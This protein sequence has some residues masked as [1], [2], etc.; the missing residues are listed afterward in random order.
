[1]NY[2]IDYS[3]NQQFYI[4]WN[5][6]YCMT[7]KIITEISSEVLKYPAHHDSEYYL[8]DKTKLLKYKSMFGDGDGQIQNYRIPLP[9]EKGLHIK[10]YPNNRFKVHWDYC[11]LKSNPLGHLI[12]D[13][14]H[15]I[16]ILFVAIGFLYLLRKSPR[17]YLFG[18][19][20][21]TVI[22]FT[23]YLIT[24]TLSIWRG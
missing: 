23:P 4:I 13:A 16:I 7:N 2:S 8:L 18:L 10:E 24:W 21:L 15:H 11:D 9:D 14:P 22:L 3:R 12:R 6:L 5:Q 17:F 20:I 1:M 19:F